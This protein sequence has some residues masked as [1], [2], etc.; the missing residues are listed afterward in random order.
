MAHTHTNSLPFEMLEVIIY[1][2][3]IGIKYYN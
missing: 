1:D 3:N 2:H